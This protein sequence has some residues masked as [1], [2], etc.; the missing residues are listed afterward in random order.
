[1]DKALVQILVDP[2]L[3]RLLKLRAVR[4]GMTLQEVAYDALVCGL[5][6]VSEAEAGFIFARDLEDAKAAAQ[7][8]QAA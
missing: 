8:D 7:E 3:K 6:P 4:L 5:E 1:M 2:S